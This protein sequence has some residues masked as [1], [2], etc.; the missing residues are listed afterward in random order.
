MGGTVWKENV[1][2]LGQQVLT[3]QCS[4]VLKWS[5]YSTVTTKRGGGSSVGAAFK[6]FGLQR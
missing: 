3:S 1:G 5:R 2:E 4:K 6:H